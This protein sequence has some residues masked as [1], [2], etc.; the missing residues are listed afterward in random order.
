MQHRGPGPTKEQ[1]KAVDVEPCTPPH[2]TW[3]DEAQTGIRRATCPRTNAGGCCGHILPSVE[4]RGEAHRG[5]H[6]P[7]EG[8]PKAASKL[9][10]P[11]RHQITR[12]PM[13]PD[14]VLEEELCCLLGGWKLEQCHKPDQDGC[15]T[16]GRRQASSK[17]QG[18]MRPWTRRDRQCRDLGAMTEV[19][20]SVCT[21]RKI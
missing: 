9:G 10:S 5:S 14:H 17:V 15:V 2:G 11:I 4:A 6:E 16:P 8:L 3:A 18:D 13:Y 12:H 1:P 21:S 20:C 7:A 19:P